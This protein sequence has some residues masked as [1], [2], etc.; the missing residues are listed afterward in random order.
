MR[1]LV[2]IPMTDGGR[3]MLRPY[4]M[5]KSLNLKAKRYHPFQREGRD[6][7]IEKLSCSAASYFP[8]LL[9]AFKYLPNWRLRSRQ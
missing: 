7:M 5:I 8:L 4:T 2:G 9:G 3:S 6:R 1:G